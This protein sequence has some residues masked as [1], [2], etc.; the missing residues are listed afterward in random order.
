MNVHLVAPLHGRILRD[1]LAEEA[2]TYHV[3]VEEGH[4]DEIWLVLYEWDAGWE[5]VASFRM[6]RGDDYEGE[7]RSRF[8]PIVDVGE[9]I[10][11]VGESI[12]IVEKNNMGF[13]LLVYD[14]LLI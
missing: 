6:R 13:W 7:V 1:W 8:A 2:G 9:N 3:L 5:R 11:A 4:L 12:V 14:W 10:D